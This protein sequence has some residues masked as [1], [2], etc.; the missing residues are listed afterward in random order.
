MR[1]DVLNIVNRIKEMDIKV[2]Y[3]Q[4]AR[5]MNCDPRTVKNY[6]L[7]EKTNSR[8]KNLRK[9]KIDDFK[10]IIEDKTDNYFAT[11]MS[12]F[13]FIEKKGYTGK[14]G[15]VKNY[16]RK[17]KKEHLKK[18]TIR[19]E[20]N[21]GLQGQVDFKEAKT[22]ISKSGVKFKINIFLYILGFSRKKFLIA[23]IDKSQKTVFN[24]LIEAFKYTTG[25]PKEIL[26]D[27]M[28][29]VVDRHDIITSNVTFNKKFSQFAKDFNFTPIACKPYRPQTKGKVEALAKLTNR[30]D[31]YNEEF[32][33]FEEL[34]KIVMKLTEEINSEVS[35]A[36]NKTP[37]SRF[38][39]EK[40][41][42]QGLPNNDIIES[43]IDN[44][45]ERKVTKE[46][47]IVYLGNKYS[48]PIDFIGKS[49]TIKIENN[50]IRILRN[51]DLIVS[52]NIS[53]KLFNYKREHAIDILKS[54]AYKD[55]TTQEIED[56]I[57]KNLNHMDI[58]LS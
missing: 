23:T 35:Q 16:I 40:E 38:E 57:E 4:I 31:V 41:Y 13:N 39:E 44:K 34:Q 5:K 7:G 51:K 20:T 22:M 24:S 6:T 28:A 56:C 47:M 15:L 45:K 3:N 46:S 42:L 9:S 8:K 29:T 10:N 2:N 17:H 54:E 27:N 26:F 58:L 48:V 52:H 12:I 25:V 1:K 55:K 36:I 43:Y 19:F 53:N 32:E 30:L 21:P 14:Y 49:M 11:A 18:A 33:T 50:I 37:N